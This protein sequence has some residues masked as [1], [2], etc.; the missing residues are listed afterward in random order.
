MDERGEKEDA[1]WRSEVIVRRGANG[2]IVV[3]FGAARFTLFPDRVVVKG[4]KYDSCCR[5]ADGGYYITGRA[6]NRPLSVVVLPT[7]NAGVE[8]RQ[9]QGGI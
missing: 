4:A 1:D 5:G 3:E 6:G 9:N 2:E 7:E 8:R